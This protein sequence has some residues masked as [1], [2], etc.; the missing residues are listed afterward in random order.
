MHHYSR[1]FYKHMHNSVHLYHEQKYLFSLYLFFSLPFT[2]SFLRTQTK[3]ISLHIFIL[4]L[5]LWRRHTHVHTLKQMRQ[6][7]LWPLYVSWYGLSVLNKH[8]M[9]ALDGS[10]YFPITGRPNNI[11]PIVCIGDFF[12]ISNCLR[13]FLTEYV[14]H[15]S[16]LI[17][18][19]AF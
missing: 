6:L 1:W 17:L 5:N 10:I 8:L 12:H 7:E 19:C 11:G 14:S 13:T 18:S 4:F 3:S 2:I 15:D 9:A 16:F